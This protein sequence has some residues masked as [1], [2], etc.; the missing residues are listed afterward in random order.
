MSTESKVVQLTFVK[1][2]KNTHVY[3]DQAEDAA[4]PSVYIK[5]QSLPSKPPAAITITIEWES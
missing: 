2:T 4:I 3:G 5:S 1:S